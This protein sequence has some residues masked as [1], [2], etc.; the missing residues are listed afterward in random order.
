MFVCFTCFIPVQKHC[1]FFTGLIFNYPLWKEIEDFD[2]EEVLDLKLVKLLA[3]SSRA[4]S[5]VTHYRS[6][7]ARWLSFAIS[8]G[9]S[10]VPASY[11]GLA[12]YFNFLRKTTCS[13]SI[14]ESSKIAIAWAHRVSGFSNPFENQWLVN[15]IEGA[16]WFTAGPSVSKKPVSPDIFRSLCSNTDFSNLKQLRITCMCVLLYSGFFRISELL[17]LKASNI[18]FLDSHLSINLY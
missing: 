14:I 1:L 5:T 8:K 16:V 15:I 6:L 3:L 7:V 2:E 18:S 11:F 13:K 4:P 10:C 9:F 17:T 12:S